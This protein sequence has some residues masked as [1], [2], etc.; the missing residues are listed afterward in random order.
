MEEE[1]EIGQMKIY[2]SR[3]S[4]LPDD[5]GGVP[6]EH[7]PGLVAGSD[8]HFVVIRLVVREGDRVGS[9][10]GGDVVRLEEV[11]ELAVNPRSVLKCGAGELDY[12]RDATFG[13]DGDGHARVGPPLTR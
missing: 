9:G 5:A 4:A 1:D 12:W 2:R 8:C 7:P 10:D 11:T 13:I 6:H 3:S